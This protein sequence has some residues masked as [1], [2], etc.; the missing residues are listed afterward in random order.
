MPVTISENMSFFF[1]DRQREHFGSVGNDCA[2][3]DVAG[4]LVVYLFKA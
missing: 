2:S 3:W 4:F 1:A